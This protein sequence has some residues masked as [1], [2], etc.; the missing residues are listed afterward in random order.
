MIILS[1]LVQ[2]ILFQRSIQLVSGKNNIILSNSS[3]IINSER[4]HYDTAFL[5]YWMQNALQNNNSNI[6]IFLNN[7][8]H[9]N[10]QQSIVELEKVCESWN[11]GTECQAGVC[12][13][14]VAL[15]QSAIA[16]FHWL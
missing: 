13:V 7:Y 10:Q 3:E 2:L 8:T 14:D 5:E 16:H 15:E 12:G 11:E 6:D 9:F 4:H 1:V